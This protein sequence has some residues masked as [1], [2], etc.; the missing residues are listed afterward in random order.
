MFFLVN[1]ASGKTFLALEF[2]L[3]KKEFTQYSVK[4]ELK[5]GMSTVS[6][7][8]K[9]CLEM[10][11][12]KSDGKKYFLIDPVG[13]IEAVSFFHSMK[14]NLLFETKFSI[15]KSEL[16]KLLPKNAIFCLES[17]LEKYD[18]FYH[19][20]T[21]S[22]YLPEKDL[23]LL[24]KNLGIAVGEKTVLKVFKEKPKLSKIEKIDGKNF[25]SKIR[26][27]IDLACD[28]KGAMGDKLISEIF[29]GN[30]NER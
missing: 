28:K 14:K 17:A 8:F 26:T 11:F 16:E 3:E 19:S 22:I 18:N 20:S 9:F 6:N 27:L 25:T 12:V 30:V 1:L 24:E 23:V 15:E 2:L 21:V 13:L 10:G 29:G 7:L 5:L 4:K